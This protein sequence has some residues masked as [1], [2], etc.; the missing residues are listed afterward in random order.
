V[1]DQVADVPD[2]APFTCYFAITSDGLPGYFQRD[3]YGNPINCTVYP[4]NNVIPGY[5]KCDKKDPTFVQNMQTK[6][7]ELTNKLQQM[8]LDKWGSLYPPGQQ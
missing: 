4:K 6:A 5:D 3:E 1:C 2:F 7:L 8:R